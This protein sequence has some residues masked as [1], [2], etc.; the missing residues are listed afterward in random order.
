[1]HEYMKLA[2]QICKYKSNNE[3]MEYIEE[4]MHNVRDI[5]EREA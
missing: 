3:L 1:M 2:Y 5:I 4:M